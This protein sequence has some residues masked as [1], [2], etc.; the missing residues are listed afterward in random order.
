MEKSKIPAAQREA[1]SM[2]LDDHRAVKKLFKE[3]ENAKERSQQEQIAQQTCHELTVHAQIEEEIFYPGVRGQSDDLDDMLDEAKVE[4]QVAKDLIAAIEGDLG[5][6]M[7][8][9]NYKV[10]SEYVSHHVQEE[11][12]E[13]FKKVMKSGIDLKEAAQQMLARKEELMAAMA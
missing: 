11:E 1:I 9:A 10:L 2:L 5:G 6:E 4:H 12:G 13:L 8:E 7:L 3:F